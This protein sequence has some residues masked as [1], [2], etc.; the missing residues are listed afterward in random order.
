MIGQGVGM[1]VF[2]WCV[3][4]FCFGV[5]IGYVAIYFGWVAYSQQFHVL[6]HDGSRIMRVELEWAPMGAIA[7]G[8]LMAFWSA[9]RAA[10]RATRRA[11]R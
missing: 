3:F 4:G 6:D 9:L 11:T 2:L 1:R 10:K 7:M 8:L 5:A